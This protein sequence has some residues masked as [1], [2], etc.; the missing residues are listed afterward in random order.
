LCYEFPEFIIQIGKTKFKNPEKVAEAPQ[1]AARESYRVL[2]IA[3]GK[4]VF[5]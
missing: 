2:N 5:P 4:T 1:K 3:I